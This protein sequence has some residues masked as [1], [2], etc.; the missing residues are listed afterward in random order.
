M[1][2]KSTCEKITLLSLLA[3]FSWNMTLLAQPG[4]ADSKG[5]ESSE[6]I[7]FRQPAS[8]WLEALPLGN[9]TIGAMVFGGTE[10]DRIQFNENSLVTGTADVV[11]FYQPFGNIYSHTGHQEVSGYK[12]SLDLHNALHSITYLHKGVNYK[13]EYF[14]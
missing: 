5:M 9:G 6:K 8:V 11:G 12:R 14:I 10:T 7:W 4:I 13:R 1:S 3:I 2:F